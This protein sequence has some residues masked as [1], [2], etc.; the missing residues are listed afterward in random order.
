MHGR[1]GSFHPGRIENR[2]SKVG[3]EAE[4]QEKG[5]NDRQDAKAPQKG[6]KI[7]APMLS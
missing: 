3:E 5:A 6:N 2:V 7:W 1:P 4:G